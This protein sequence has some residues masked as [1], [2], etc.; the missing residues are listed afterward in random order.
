MLRDFFEKVVEMP[1][2]EQIR[3][4]KDFLDVF[5]DSGKESP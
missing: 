5:D 3:I 2:K 1:I 4:I